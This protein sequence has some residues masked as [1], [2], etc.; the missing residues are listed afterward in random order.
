MKLNLPQKRRLLM[1]PALLI[2]A[3]LGNLIVSTSKAAMTPTPAATV[4]T[5]YGVI[6]WGDNRVEQVTIP[7]AAQSGV[8]AKPP[9]TS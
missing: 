7:A 4:M 2:A 9:T 5:D 1:L 8:T 6:G 3:L